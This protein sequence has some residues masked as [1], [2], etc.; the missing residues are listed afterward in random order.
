MACARQTKQCRGPFYFLVSRF[1]IQGLLEFLR[2]LLSLAFLTHMSILG[3][4]FSPSEGIHY[5]VAQSSTLL[6][7]EEI[8]KPFPLRVCEI[9]WLFH[10]R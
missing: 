7:L 10:L 8:V 1:C 3:S 5:W 4:A 6:L 2:L 9:Q